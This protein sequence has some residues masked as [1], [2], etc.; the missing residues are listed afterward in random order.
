MDSNLDSCQLRLQGSNLGLWKRYLPLPVHFIERAVDEGSSNFRCGIC[1][2]L[3]KMRHMMT[4]SNAEELK[5][6]STIFQCQDS[7]IV[8]VAHDEIHLSPL[9][10]ATLYIRS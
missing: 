2:N 9:Y 3:I 6:W 10:A 5:V 4:A 7:L 8:I 1:K